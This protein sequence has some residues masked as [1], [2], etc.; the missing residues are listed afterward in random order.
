MGSDVGAGPIGGS[1]SKHCCGQ[2]WVC[3][4]PYKGAA[5][6]TPSVCICVIRG[7]KKGGPARHDKRGQAGVRM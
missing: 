1:V 7:C 6:M 4:P 5:R 2:R 3:D